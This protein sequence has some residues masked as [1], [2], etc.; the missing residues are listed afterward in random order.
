MICINPEDLPV[1]GDHP[2]PP[3]I[4][5]LGSIMGHTD[6]AE[7]MDPSSML[8]VIKNRWKKEINRNAFAFQSGME[9]NL[10]K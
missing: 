3:N 9:A 2:V 5:I 8:L 10:K 4:F 1:Y 6:M 7:I